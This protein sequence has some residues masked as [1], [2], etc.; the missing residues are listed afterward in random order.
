[1]PVFPVRLSAANDDEYVVDPFD[2]LM[3]YTLRALR[4]E[5]GVSLGELARRLDL[6]PLEL[7]LYERG[8]LRLTVER[9]LAMAVALDMSIEAF[10]ADR[11][12]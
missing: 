6:T 5:R 1:M 10:Y 11:T 7:S 2:A 3:G 8:E 9:L 4:L 12:S